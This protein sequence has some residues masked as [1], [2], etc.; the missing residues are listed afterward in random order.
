M[1]AGQNRDLPREEA[2]KLVTQALEEC[3]D[4]AG[5][6][7]IFLGLENHD[8]IGS[9]EHLLKLI[10]AVRSKWLG[11]NLDSGNFHTADPYTDFEKCIPY[12]VNVQVKTDIRREGSKT[13]EPADLPRILRL[14][15]EGGYQGFVALEFE[16]NEDPYEAVPPLLQRLRSLMGA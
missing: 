11:V 13:S 10:G 9:A 3:C 4:Y 1:F 5:A 8:A 7:G 16:A 14:L 15:R 12:A 6:R 2:D